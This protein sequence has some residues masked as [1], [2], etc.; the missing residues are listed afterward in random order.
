MISRFITEE[1]LSI[2]YSAAVAEIP[3]V[4]LNC[5][6]SQEHKVNSDRDRRGNVV[7]LLAAGFS[8]VLPKMD[9]FIW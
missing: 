8:C 1:T 2:H 7:S 5:C 3:V 4:T 9:L 6:P